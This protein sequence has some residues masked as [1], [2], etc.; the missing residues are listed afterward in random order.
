[1]IVGGVIQLLPRK[2]LAPVHRYGLTAGAVVLVALVQHAL[3]GV[4]NGHVFFLY[5]PAVFLA[6][7]LLDRW[8]GVLAVGLS[9]LFLAWFHLEPFGALWIADPAAALRLLLFVLSA[10]AI[11]VVTD[12]LHRSLRAVRDAHDER[13]I[14]VRDIHHRIRRDLQRVSPLLRKARVGPRH[15]KDEAIDL[16]VERIGILSRAYTCLRPDQNVVTVDASSFLAGLVEDL[17][18]STV[19]LG[20]II[21]Q[22]AVDDADLDVDCAVTLGIVLNELVTDAFKH[23]FPA[24]GLGC[25]DVTFRREGGHCVLAV[26]SN[27][28]RPASSLDEDEGEPELLQRLALQLGGTLDPQS[29]N[30]TRVTLR[31]PARTTTA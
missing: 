24:T 5:F 29:G 6:A 4:L 1:M 2:P 25:I 22:S 30:G 9:A 19:G 8:C 28:L 18:L 13:Q 21:L 15:S 11:A 23:A 3:A 10:L 31:F 20:S 26:A 17:R 7:L 27:G 12:A 16:A 14:L